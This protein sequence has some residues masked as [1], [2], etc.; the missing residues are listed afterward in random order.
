MREAGAAARENQP[1]TF[2]SDPVLVLLGLGEVLGG[3]IGE[4]DPV[5]ALGPGDLGPV[6]VGPGD[7][8]PG[9]LVGRGAVALAVVEVLGGEEALPVGVVAGGVVSEVGRAGWDRG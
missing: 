3:D 8:A 4:P 2:Q 1:V 9:L 5:P 7:P 6:P